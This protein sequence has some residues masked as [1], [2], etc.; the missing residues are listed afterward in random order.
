MAFM[1]ILSS[2]ALASAAA[3]V[4]T[5]LPTALPTPLPA[6]LPTPLPTVTPA[7]FL[8][9]DLGTAGGFVVL[10]KSGIST[11]PDSVITGD[12][13]VSP[14]TS[15]AMTGF[16]FAADA[17]GTF[18]TSVQV[19]GKAYAANFI[20]PTPSELTTAVSDMEAAYTDAAGRAI[21]NGANSDLMAG[22][23]TGAS[24]E[25][26]VYAWGTDINFSGDITLKG[27]ATD[28]FIFKTTGN[29][30]VGSG[31]QVILEGGVLAANIV[32]QVA[33][34]LDAGTTS[35]LEGI[36]LVKTRAVFKTLSSLNGRILAQ[37]A[38]TLDAATISEPPSLE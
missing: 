19:V 26:G 7:L 28:L 31:A 34:F 17:S 12:I 3:L 4:P 27:S 18:S 11:V 16:D 10:S 22:L 13:G 35:H 21:S 25:A 5:A 33:G 38:V 23:I 20:S 36:F 32:W 8:P 24:F 15:A 14:I 29:V 9:V 30:I 37:T 6:P 2:L 1:F